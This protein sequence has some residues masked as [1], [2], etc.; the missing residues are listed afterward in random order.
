MTVSEFQLPQFQCLP[1]HCFGIVQLTERVVQLGL[2]VVA[3]TEGGVVL[4]HDVEVLFTYHL[5][6]MQQLSGQGVLAF[7][8][9]DGSSVSDS[10]GGFRMRSS[11]V[12]RPVVQRALIV[13]QR[14]GIVAFQHFGRGEAGVTLAHDHFIFQQMAVTQI[15]SFGQ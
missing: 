12:L 7:D 4:V 10:G 1:H 15:Q 3:V 13:L 2:Q 6:I 11:E 5:T 14:L 9:M 8:E